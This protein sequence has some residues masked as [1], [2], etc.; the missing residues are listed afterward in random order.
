MRRV[1]IWGVGAMLAFLVT[2]GAFLMLANL[3]SSL[4]TRGVGPTPAQSNS[5]PP[6]G[7]NLSEAS[8]E[9]LKKEADQVLPLTVD[10]TSESALSNISLTM[11][12]TS[13]N[14]AQLRARYYRATIKELAPGASKT[15]RFTLDLSS[16]KPSERRHPLPPDSPEP[17]SVLEV[18]ATTPE[19]VS[20]IKTAVLPF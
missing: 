17:R 16:P 20:A 2:A 9:E 1:L 12:V 3:S 6:L 5:A 18:Q 15:V 8:L 13:E 10:N 7:L 11:R 14:T 4:S 19:G